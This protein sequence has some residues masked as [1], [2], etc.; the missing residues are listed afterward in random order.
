MY[1]YIFIVEVV[2]FGLSCSPHNSVLVQASTSLVMGLG[3]LAIDPLNWR[4]AVGVM[5]VKPRHIDQLNL[6]VPD[7]RE[8]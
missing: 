4:G 3:A 5:P 7:T 6:I 8:K 2:I 1:V